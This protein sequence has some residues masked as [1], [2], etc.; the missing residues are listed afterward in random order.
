MDIRSAM[1]TFGFGHRE[2]RHIIIDDGGELWLAAAP[3]PVGGFLPFGATSLPGTLRFEPLESGEA[4]PFT[5]TATESLLEL[6]TAKGAVVRA[7]IDAGAQAVRVTGNTAFRLNAVEAAMMSTS[8]ITEKGITLGAGTI[9]YLFVVKKGKWTF[10]DTYQLSKF[11]SVTAVLSI[12]P[13]DG[14]FELYVYDLPADTDVPVIT[15][16]LDE[17]ADENA[18]AFK[19]F[20]ATLVSVPEE[21]A[22]VVLTAAYPLWLCH[23]VLDGKEV[24]VE[25]KYKTAN[26]GSRLLSIASLAF[27]DAKK[28]VELILAY[29]VETP[30]VAGIAASRLF[31]DN[32]INDSR[33][34]I[35]RVY[36][37]LETAARRAINE[38]TTCKDGL[39][40]YA[41][42]FESGSPTPPKFFEV[43]EPVLAPD[44]NAYLVIVSEIIGK[45]AKLEYDD[46][47]AQKWGYRAKELQRQLI[48]E[49]W[50]G[51]DFVGKNAYTGE[52]SEPDEFLSL[53]PVVLGARLPTDIIA[54]LKSKITAE[55]TESA[56]GFVLVSGL[57]DAGERD[58]ARD[59]A[60][61]ALKKVRAEG[62]SCPFYGASLLALA[63]KV[64]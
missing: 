9:S 48:G 8:L 39:S 19:D 56:I 45:L 12:E 22:D 54:K 44:L 31:D 15:K 4:V 29:P 57:Y 64:L 41:Y 16:T 26:T 34:E 30:P 18:A 52:L 13:E 40:F 60:L 10:D 51:E 63:H 23:R 27:N 62:I 21:W 20:L 55:N 61:A 49:L 32:L 17:V 38:R 53:V 25:N 58:A 46:G 11:T 43:G 47:M 35:Y 2:T 24:I 36:A 50:N 3:A 7:A 6:T 28:A 33:G 5:Y 14:E 37:A 1:S 42:R 59:I